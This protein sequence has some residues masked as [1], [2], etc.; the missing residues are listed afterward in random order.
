M[1]DHA[2]PKD[3]LKEEKLNDEDLKEEVSDETSDN[4][5]QNLSLEKIEEIIKE[6]KSLKEENAKYKNQLYLIAEK[7]ETNKKEN[8]ANQQRFQKEKINAKNNAIKDFANDLLTFLDLS[9][10]VMKSILSLKVENDNPVYKQLDSTMQ[11]IKMLFDLMHDALNK[12]GLYKMN[13]IGKK[14]DPQLHEASETT[15]DDSKE[16]DIIIKV[17]RE[18]YKLNDN[19]LRPA[20]VIVNEIKEKDKKNNE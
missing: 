18:G 13:S 6:N 19:I 14:F 9:D 15:C 11:G 4:N 12:N 8:D 10:P 3:Q 1:K 7:Y 20:N 16:H 2:K 17:I 5:N